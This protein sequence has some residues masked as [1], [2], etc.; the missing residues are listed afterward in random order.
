MKRLVPLL[1]LI[2]VAGYAFA[3]TGSDVASQ[4]LAEEVTLERIAAVALAVLIVTGLSR[5][6]RPSAS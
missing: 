3:G 5:I 1:L 4:V 6:R 2:L